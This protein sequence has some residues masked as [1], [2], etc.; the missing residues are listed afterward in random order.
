MIKLK[1]I[2]KFYYNKGIVASGITK[3]NLELKTSEFVTI[4]GESGSGKSTIL[5]IISGLDTYDEGEMYI[6][7][8]ETSH[9]I[10]SDYEHYSR[11]YIGNIFQNFN[12]I[13]SYT[14]KQ[15]IEL[16]LLLNGLPTNKVDNLIKIVN[17]TE[18]K[19]T[20]VSKLSGGQKQRVAIARALAKETPIIIA[21]EPTG[22]IDSKSSEE[23]IKILNEISKEKLVIVVTHN[24]EQFEK[25]TTR[26]IKMS[27]GKIIEDN[28]IKQRI[29]PEKIMLS[30]SNEMSLSNKI[31]LAFKN[32]YNILPKF[33]LLLFVFTFVSYML[34][35]S[36]TASLKAEKQS[37]EM[38][39]NYLLND[40]STNRI[41]VKKQNND[42]FT[43]ED[44]DKLKDYKLIK[45]DILLDTTFTFDTKEQY[46]LEGTILNINDV[47]NIILTEGQ[48]PQ[49]EN[50]VIIVINPNYY[51]NF[52]LNSELNIISEYGE[53]FDTK[54]KITGIIHDENSQLYSKI[55]VQEEK[56]NQFTYQAYLNKTEVRLKTENINIDLKNLKEIILDE[57]IKEGTIKNTYANATITAKNVYI[58]NEIILINEEN[59]PKDDNIYIN[60][61]DLNKLINTDDY[62]VSIYIDETKL[63]QINSNLE[64][65]GFQ[66]LIVK[67]T[68]EISTMIL[69][70][71]MTTFFMITIVMLSMFFIAYFIISL[72]FKSRNVYYSTIRILGSTVTTCKHLLLIELLIVSTI[73]Y[74]MNLLLLNIINNQNFKL[75]KET[76]NLNN[77]LFIYALVALLTFLI[78]KKYSK[79][80]FKDTAM[81]TIAEEV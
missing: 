41:I 28:I 17:L 14:V 23:I 73:G 47:E 48:M 21:D 74:L 67:D 65:N 59:D 46:F 5:N 18:Y 55:L 61:K 13:T 71:K 79:K 34:S 63:N 78:S 25:Y 62:Q 76:L 31:K 22:N 4:T 33:L 44:Y 66:T 77:Y 7:N 9:Y 30:Q 64:E 26:K 42:K 81:K 51:L 38:G 11:T 49:N 54:I 24:Y 58:N 32:S 16:V 43:E 1:N 27:D 29:Q 53:I 52:Q 6:N 40:I 68:L 69:A 19:N 12:L 70:F 50:E 2:S 75:I 3:I 39:I 60:P 20:K 45:N 57:S 36:I 72:I 15:N 80:L 37:Y 56:I 35:S 10:Q 8:E